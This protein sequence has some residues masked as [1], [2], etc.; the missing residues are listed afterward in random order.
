MR[1][2]NPRTSQCCLARDEHRCC[3]DVGFLLLPLVPDPTPPGTG[4]RAGR[5]LEHEV[6]EL[7]GDGQHTI[8][9]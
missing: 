8:F 3:Q 6:G 1:E 4:G 9:E 5:V 7:V 2:P